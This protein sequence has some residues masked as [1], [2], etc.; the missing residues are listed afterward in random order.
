MSKPRILISTIQGDSTNYQKAIAKADGLPI[1]QY[2]PS[3]H[4]MFD[5]LL[6]AG[7]GDIDPVFLGEE[8]NGSYN[9]DHARDLAEFALVE[10]CLAE[11][12]PILGICRGHQVVNVA[13]GGTLLQDMSE[14]DRKRHAYH[15]REDRDSFHA[16]VTSK[17]SLMRELFGKMSVVNSAHH[18]TILKEGR[19]MKATAWSVPYVLEATEHESRPIC[20]VQFHPERL[21]GRQEERALALF[22]W[23]VK[24]CRT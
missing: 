2:C 14:I 11:N 20:S 23:F 21:E 5:G 17:P 16:M 8:N 3:V 7:G 4:L 9:I 13:L 15:M 24:A 6:L 1:A 10:H 19:G 18:Q 12:K 22:S